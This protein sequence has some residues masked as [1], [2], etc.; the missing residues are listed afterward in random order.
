MQKFTFLFRLKKKDLNI[1]AESTKLLNV[2]LLVSK[3]SNQKVY[4]TNPETIYKAL[5]KVREYMNNTY[6]H[7]LD[8]VK[9]D[10]LY[11]MVSRTDAL[12]SCAYKDFFRVE[13]VSVVD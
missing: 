7:G 10:T 1:I 9:K 6:F 11:S 2:L 3:N 8:I 12:K 13:K 4:N 5:S